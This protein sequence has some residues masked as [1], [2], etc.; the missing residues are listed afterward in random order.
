[1]TYDAILLVSFGG[2][3][4]RD[5]VI[6]FLEN[7]LRGKPVPRERLLEVAEHYYHFDGVSPINEQC[8]RLIRA[9]RG[10]LDRRG[11]TLPIFWG[12]R[13]W[14]PY[15]TDT[16]RE[17]TERGYGKVLAV[18][19][20]AYSS[21]SGCR[22]YRE[23]VIAAREAVGPAAPHVDK[24]RVFYNHPDF[25]AANVD[26]IRA[27]ERRLTTRDRSRRHLVFTA[28]SIPMSMSDQCDYRRQLEET[29][30]LVALEL[31]WPSDQYRLVYQS[32]SGRPEDPWLEPDVCDH[33]R[34]LHSQGARDVVIS[35]VG[36]LSD[37]ME[38]MFDLDVE[39]KTVCE[40]LGLEMVRAA[41]PGEHP[42]FASMLAELIQER[43]GPSSERRAIGQYPANHDVCPENCCPSPIRRGGPPSR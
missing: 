35:P 23:N 2:P 25:I 29:C 12:N 40:E 7:V 11:L 42:R 36:F 1:M 10:E 38:V 4:G 22:Q 21:Y 18:M 41:T 28:H 17:L 30:R 26:E 14:N 32:R 37:H 24:L 8:R 33:L 39:A 27:A 16:M 34:T 31:E 3:E 6:P 5:D 13:N 19:T 9:L 43:M 15:L 20:S